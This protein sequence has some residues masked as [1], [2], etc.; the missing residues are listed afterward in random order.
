M[1]PNGKHH[2]STANGNGRTAVVVFGLDQHGRPKAARFAEKFAGRAAKAAAQMHLGI[3]AVGSEDVEAVAA[4][5]PV[6]RIYANGRGFVPY[7]R[8]DLYDKLVMVAAGPGS[9]SP[10]AAARP[11]SNGHPAATTS[12]KGPMNEAGSSGNSAGSGGLPGNWDEIAPGHLVIAQESLQDG[13]WEA[14]VVER[15]D[16][17]LTLRWRDYP[18]YKPFL[19]Y[20]DAVALLRRSA[21]G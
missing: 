6:G 10:K 2:Q 5:L 3:V 18:K 20:V 16:D 8:R 14:I 12:P 15:R 7:V 4:R 13:W 9:S 1:K 19:C 17:M 11:G 21:E